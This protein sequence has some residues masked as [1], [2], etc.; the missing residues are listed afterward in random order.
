MKPSQEVLPC[1]GGRFSSTVQPFLTVLLFCRH[2]PPVFSAAAGLSRATLLWHKHF[3]QGFHNWLPSLTSEPGLLAK[4]V[5]PSNVLPTLSPANT[6]TPCFRSASLVMGMEKDWNGACC[7][8][9]GEHVVSRQRQRTFAKP[10]LSNLVQLFLVKLSLSDTN[11][12]AMKKASGF[13]LLE[14]GPY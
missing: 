11:Q 7:I 1:L 13:W 9:W 3:C 5:S 8:H 14:K 6:I 2:T 10:A 12:R 4:Y